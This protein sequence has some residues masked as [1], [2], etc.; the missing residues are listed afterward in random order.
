MHPIS[1]SVAPLLTWALILSSLAKPTPMPR[2]YRI[3]DIV[4]DEGKLFVDGYAIDDFLPRFGKLDPSLISS[5][6]QPRILHQR[7]CIQS[8]SIGISFGRPGRMEWRWLLQC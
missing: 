8:S 6:M 3:G 4:V 2:P 7:N 5:I 1:L